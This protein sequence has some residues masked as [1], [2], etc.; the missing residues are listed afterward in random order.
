L[1]D[2]RKLKVHLLAHDLVLKIYEVTADV[3]AGERFGL[4]S[5]LR[6]AAASIP[7]NLAEGAG[8]ASSQVFA[9]H[10][11][12]AIGSSSEV[13]YGLT[14]CRD[15]DSSNR[16]LLLCGSMRSHTCVR[17]C[18]V[19]V[20]LCSTCGDLETLRLRDREVGDRATA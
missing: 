13:E 12:I 15:L 8:R 3:D 1:R 20:D 19:F 17:C 16:R 14:L 11:D 6:R 18:C 10:V 5:Q 9:R 7:L 4:V 2:Y